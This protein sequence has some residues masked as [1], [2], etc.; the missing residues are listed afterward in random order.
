MKQPPK[1]NRYDGLEAQNEAYIDEISS[2]LLYDNRAVVLT[3]WNICVDD[4]TR[5][6]VIETSI[7]AT[8][9][10]P[11]D[12]LHIAESWNSAGMIG[13]EQIFNTRIIDKM[14][15]DAM[16]ERIRKSRGKPGM[17]PPPS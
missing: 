13:S 2:V 5:N 8:T 9:T 4:V 15:L 14:L 6:N 7:I 3:V 12:A 16:I 10:D 1:R 11:D 17:L